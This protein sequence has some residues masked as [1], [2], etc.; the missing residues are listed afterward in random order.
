MIAAVPNLKE[1]VLTSDPVPVV[2]CKSEGDYTQDE[3]G[4]NASQTPMQATTNLS[5]KFGVIPVTQK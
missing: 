3:E 4:A 1:E 2:D 5:P